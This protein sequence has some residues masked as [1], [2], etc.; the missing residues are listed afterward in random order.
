MC[1]APLAKD[2]RREF[3]FKFGERHLLY[4]LFAFHLR[5]WT[6]NTFPRLEYALRLYPRVEVR[7][8]TFYFILENK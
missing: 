1:L 2:K 3:G 4:V 5:S 8:A 6:L 7:I